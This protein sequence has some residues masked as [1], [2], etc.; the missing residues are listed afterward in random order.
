MKTTISKTRRWALIALSAF[1]LAAGLT[2][3]NVGRASHASPQISHPSPPIAHPD[4]PPDYGDPKKPLQKNPTG[5][6]DNQNGSM[7]PHWGKVEIPTCDLPKGFMSWSDDK[8]R[9]WCRKQLDDKFG[10]TNKFTNHELVETKGGSKVLAIYKVDMADHASSGRPLLY[11]PPDPAHPG[12]K[13]YWG[14][15]AQLKTLDKECFKPKKPD[16][17]KSYSSTSDGT[18]TCDICQCADCMGPTDTYCGDDPLW[19]SG[20]GEVGS[21]A[22]P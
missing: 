2:H 15:I 20:S 4:D 11:H 6:G 21:D 17:S 14:G 9:K 10:M 16:K 22:C 7:F 12:T 5:M 18:E 8:Q 3:A 19:C 1:G 13:K